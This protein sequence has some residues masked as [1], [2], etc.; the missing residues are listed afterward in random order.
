ML[1]ILKTPIDLAMWVKLHNLIQ[2]KK[3]SRDGKTVVD[4]L[5]RADLKTMLPGEKLTLVSHGSETSFGGY[6][7][8]DLAKKLLSKGLRNDLSSIKLS[9]CK[10]GSDAKGTPFCKT[11]SRTLF[12]LTKH[13]S[14]AIK[15]EVTGFVGTA[16]TFSD[17]T[18]RSKPQIQPPIV[19]PTYNEIIDK[20]EKSGELDTWKKEALNLPYASEKQIVEGAQKM[21]LLSKAMFE[22]LYIFNGKVTYGKA[23]SK[24]RGDW[25]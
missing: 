20:Y 7:P 2:N 23:G 16:V 10:A 12:D 18:V 8:T 4:L 15:V 21:A 19:G 14:D 25:N 13:T 3:G 17:G 6:D 22:E 11:L 5:D 24:F 9:G 1:C